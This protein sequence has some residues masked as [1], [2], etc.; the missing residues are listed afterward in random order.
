MITWSP[1]CQSIW[2]LTMSVRS[3]LL[4]VLRSHESA[5]GDILVPNET[6]PEPREIRFAKTGPKSGEEVV[7]VEPRLNEI[8]RWN[9]RR[10][11]GRVDRVPRR[12][13]SSNSAVGDPNIKYSSGPA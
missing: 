13:H 8:G 7:L 3:P 1:A 9:A 12:A 6:M 5:E 11:N 2:P 10:P 4:A